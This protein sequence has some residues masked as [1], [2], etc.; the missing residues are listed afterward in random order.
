MREEEKNPENPP[1]RLKF[2]MPWRV[3][4]VKA[5]ENYCLEVCFVDGTRGEVDMSKLI[6]SEHAG[7]FQA[8]KDERIFSQVF[9]DHGVVTWPGEIDLAPDAM[10]QEIKKHSKWILE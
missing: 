4:T 7:V 8:L 1:S 5:L 3:H 2:S 10:Y 6:L 9:V